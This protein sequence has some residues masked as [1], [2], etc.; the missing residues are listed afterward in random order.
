MTQQPGLPETIDGARLTGLH[1]LVV[2]LCAAAFAI[3]LW[4]MALTAILATVFTAQAGA[5]AAAAPWLAAS[6]FFGAIVGAPLFG[7]SADRFGRKRV[8][9]VML[10]VIGL[11]SLAA[12]AA[13]RPEAI[14]LWRGLSGTA[15][16]A[17]PAVLFAYLTDL[18]PARRRGQILI[19]VSAVAALGAPAATFLARG[20]GPEGWRLAISAGGGAALLLALAIAV[21]P[22]SP[23]WLSA[24]G[25]AAAA[26]RAWARFERSRPLG[27]AGSLPA[28]RP[29]SAPATLASRRERVALVA[30]FF[31]SA[32]VLVAFP[33]VSPAI[34]VS[35][36]VAVDDALFYVAISAL[37]P[38][39]GS[40]LGAVFVDRWDR[41]WTL[42]GCAVG[43]IAAALAFAVARHPA[44]I[45]ATGF[46]FSLIA[47][48]Y[49]PILYL[50]AG[51]KLATVERGF[52]VA[53]AWTFNRIGSA[54]APLLLL[55]LLRGQGA[56]AV[57]AV[58]IAAAG[59]SVAILVWG[60]PKGPPGQ[61]V[62]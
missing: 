41:R 34:L 38:P 50:Y 8:L 26:L 51:E 25:Q 45:L 20:A 23:R 56:P 60:A 32:W 59:A 53:F 62:R 33:I 55:P 7:A 18:L 11:C 43:L 52:G 42:A 15:M 30:L 36:G 29:P 14:A 28:A 4:E 35:R 49:I 57:L 37:G 39:V 13:R 17:F 58:M 54:L 12:G 9:A 40:L 27:R 6:V 21:L 61:A 46:A 44:A 10:G 19:G 24:A 2:A 3:D 31:L 16:G 22:E 47:L 1:L 48:I 5:A